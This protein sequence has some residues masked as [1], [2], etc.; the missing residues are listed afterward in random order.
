MSQSN[1]P[2]GFI[3]RPR[4]LSKQGEEF[5]SLLI[6]ADETGTLRDLENLKKIVSPTA[7]FSPPV[8]SS[9]F[10]TKGWS[11]DDVHEHFQEQRARASVPS[12]VQS[13]MFWLGIMQKSMKEM[14]K[15]LQ[16]VQIGKRINFLDLG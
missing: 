12:E 7:Q 15:K 11:H 4:P 14:D 5:L 10:N 1:V 6:E 3:S 16:V 9:F 8:C 2:F 13:E